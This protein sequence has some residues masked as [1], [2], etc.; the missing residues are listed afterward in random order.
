MTSISSE[1][2][3]LGCFFIKGTPLAC[4]HGFSSLP[5]LPDFEFHQ[6]KN[7]L[8]SNHIDGN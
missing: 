4:S 8:K 3:L 7:V 1:Q 6:I 2:K 5:D